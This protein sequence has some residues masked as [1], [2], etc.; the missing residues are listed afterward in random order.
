[1]KSIR[2]FITLAFLSY[3]IS[4]SLAQ[5]D[6]T[7]ISLS[8]GIIS[9]ACHGEICHGG[10]SLDLE[11][12]DYTGKKIFAGRSNGKQFGLYIIEGLK[13]GDE[14]RIVINDTAYL[15]REYVITIPESNKYRELS[16]DFLAVP[17]V[18][19]LVMKFHTPPF[20][21]R[22]SKIRYGG[23]EILYNYEILMKQNPNMIFEIECFPDDNISPE[24]NLRLT[25][26]RCNALKDYYSARG[27]KPER[28]RIK[29]NHEIDP[30]LPPPPFK[31]AKGKR[32][33]GTT[34]LRIV[35]Y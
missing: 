4:M 23:G 5:T 22:K 26:E 31:I 1:M 33:I 12:F 15:Y 13:Q 30:L 3:C 14:Y 25:V 34:Y 32:Y 19:N 7:L 27:I 18:K 28:I 10:V 6:T 20:E 8:G 29:P 11:A 9:D 2:I 21:L 16:M 24:V 17:K 35:D